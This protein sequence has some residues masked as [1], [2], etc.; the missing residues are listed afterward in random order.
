MVMNFVLVGA[1]HTLTFVATRTARRLGSVKMVN[2][3]KSI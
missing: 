1:N 3:N 2:P